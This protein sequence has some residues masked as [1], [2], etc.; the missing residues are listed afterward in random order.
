MNYIFD[1]EDSDK[2]NPFE[3]ITI[4]EEQKRY[5]EYFENHPNKKSFGE[6]CKHM[7]TIVGS[8]YCFQCFY[9]SSVNFKSKELI[10]DYK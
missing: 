5:D 1:L 9:N 6:K 8:K 7:P 2:R 10:C 3:D 4:E